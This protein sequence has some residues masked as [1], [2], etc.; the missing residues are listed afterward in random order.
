M[1]RKFYIAGVQF[2]SKNEIAKAMKEIK[3][4]DFLGL[5]P[6][7]TNQYDP[8]A[9]Q[10]EFNVETVNGIESIFLGYVPKK[11]SAGVSAFL[12]AGIELECKVD[13]VNLSAKPWEMFFVTIKEANYTESE[14]V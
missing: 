1:N 2:R 11:F 5:V 13:E 14:L 6:E 10:I 8:N 7:P 3:E 12:E 4:G 9:V